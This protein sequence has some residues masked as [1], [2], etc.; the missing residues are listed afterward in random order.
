MIDPFTIA[1]TGLIQAI[2]RPGAYLANALMPIA[3]PGPAEVF[4]A[5]RRGFIETEAAT[6]YGRG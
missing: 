5:H 4:H 2:A 1:L 3:V 6:T